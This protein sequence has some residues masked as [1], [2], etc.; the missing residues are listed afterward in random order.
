[1]KIIKRNG[2]EE[3]FS[4][5]K[6]AQA[7]SKANKTVPPQIQMSENKLK[8]SA[9][10]LSS[11]VPVQIVPFPLKRSKTLSKRVLWKKKPTMLLKNISHIV[12][13]E[14]FCAKQTPP[15]LKSFL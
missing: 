14:T 12:I 4:I 2:A 13:P 3:E 9:K 8:L 5:Q 6:I 11:H 10:E 15:M 1:M 7:I